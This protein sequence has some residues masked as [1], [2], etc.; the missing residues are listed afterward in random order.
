MRWK[1]CATPI[2]RVCRMLN[3]DFK[4]FAQLLNAYEV[5]YL[6][7]GGYALAAHGHPRYTGDLDIWYRNTHD[8]RV[9]VVSALKAFGFGALGLTEDD[10][11]DPGNVIQLGYPPRRID[12]LG[13]I[14]GVSFS[15]CWPRRETIEWNGLSLPLISLGDFKANKRATGRLKDLADLEALGDRDASNI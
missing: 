4:E 11:G 7:V 5:D 1:N 10:L 6:V 14:D 12:L 15:D 3:S 8:N 2:S 9:R 13:D